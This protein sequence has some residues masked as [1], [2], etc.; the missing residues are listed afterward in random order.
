MLLTKLTFNGQF[1]L[2][3]WVLSRVIFTV[4]TH[5]FLNKS[6]LLWIPLLAIIWMPLSAIPQSESNTGNL[7]EAKRLLESSKRLIYSNP[8]SAIHVLNKVLKL[9]NAHPFTLERSQAYR[10]IGICHDIQ[11]ELEDGMHNYDEALAIAYSIND[12]VQIGN[13]H[14]AKGIVFYRLK[15]FERALEYYIIAKDIYEKYD[16]PIQLSSARNNI[17]AIYNELRHFDRAIELFRKEIQLAKTRKDTARLSSAQTNM[18][19]AFVGNNNL[20]SAKKYVLQAIELN[21]KYGDNYGNITAYQSAGVVYKF[22]NMPDSGFYYIRKSLALLPEEKTMDHAV[23]LM[24][25]GMLFEDVGKY[26]SALFYLNESLKIYNRTNGKAFAE[27]SDLHRKIA[28]IFNLTGKRDSA[29]QHYELGFMLA[30]SVIEENAQ[31]K[32]LNFEIDHQATAFNH[33]LKESDRQRIELEIA[34]K[35]KAR[36]LWIT[37]VLLVLAMLALIGFLIARQQRAKYLKALTLQNNALEES[38]ANS[39]RMLSILAH[40]FRSPL[41]SIFV[42]IDYLMHHELSPEDKVAFSKKAKKNITTTLGAIDQLLFWISRDK[43]I[44]QPSD[45]SV[46]DAVNQSIDIHHIEIEE[47]KIEIKAEHLEHKSIFFDSRHL[48]VIVRNLIH[49]GIKHV[50]PGGRI[51]IECNDTEKFTELR[52]SDNG[53][54]I[55][56]ET[57]ELI[58]TNQFSKLRPEAKATGSGLG[59][60]LVFE[61]VHM[62]N[63]T[64]RFESALNEGTTVIVSVEKTA[65]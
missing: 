19:Y 18:T 55:P 56:A 36:W 10:F 53:A 40:D 54:G 7:D 25:M 17:G 63:A 50:A 12:S 42:M 21:E 13:I 34:N 9:T 61:L 31:E 16:Q 5:I 35:V 37:I 15:N 46:S 22:L 48:N 6:I 28:S 47:K 59:L 29:L 11:G 26:D 52:I 1:Y 2:V 58:N 51:T 43:K 14:L 41:A 60:E 27:K 64:I 38:L 24:D 4:I 39:K 20:D 45:A 32:L 65:A 33:Q 3:Y 62:N 57:L 23:V 8:D 30:D 44:V 49:N